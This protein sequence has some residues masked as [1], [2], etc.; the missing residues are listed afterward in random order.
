MREKLL[1][2]DIHL[3]ATRVSGT[4]QASQMV[5][6]EYLLASFE[7]LAF[8]HLDKDMIINGDLFDAFWVSP[9]DAL[10]FYDVARRWLKESG[11]K[12]WVGRGNHDWSKDSMKMS[13]FDMICRI[14]SAEFPDRFFAVTES[15]WLEGEIYMVPHMPNQD[16]FNLELEK[17]GE[18][19]YADGKR[20]VL[21]LHANYDNGYTA[22]SDH[23]LNVSAEQAGKLMANGW[24]L[25]FGHEHQA[26][27]ISR[28]YCVRTN[29]HDWGVIITGNQWPSSV[30]D[31]LNN[32]DNVKHAHII[33]ADL[34]LE[35]I[36]TWQ[37]DDD[38][39]QIDWRDLAAYEG[40]A[41]F[42]RVTGKAAT[43]EASDAIAAISQFR[44]DRAEVLV[45]TNAVVVEGVADMGELKATAENIK[46]FD[47]L[48]FL[49]DQL[50][51]KQ[52]A[53][54]KDLIARDENRVKEAA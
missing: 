40:G 9:L 52:A 42:I 32:P 2:N 5:I 36:V 12:L 7:R 30:A 19:K 28:S 15:Q 46:A 54:V 51:E 27:R 14:L 18:F 1:V 37:A 49:I 3:G 23:S 26:R 20:G 38:F 24:T 44:R 47:V 43:E 25:I 29:T 22:D 35:P 53:K 4:T 34:T 33:K 21:L 31:C 41:R 45:V 8:E 11:G 13:S 6:R 16:L 10:G 17:V 39:A 50:D 48:G